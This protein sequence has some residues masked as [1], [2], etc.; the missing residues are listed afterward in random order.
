M[1]LDKNNIFYLIAAFSIV[2]VQTV[3]AQNTSNPR[4]AQWQESLNQIKQEIGSLLQE[5]KEL[6][7]QYKALKGNLIAIQ[8][9][10][11]KIK[12]ENQG[13][14]SDSRQIKQQLLQRDNTKEQLLRKEDALKNQIAQQEARNKALN[15]ELNSVEEAVR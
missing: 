6:D 8:D 4:I 15:Q 7:E 9:E 11:N 3:S 2:C 14:E 5:N 10:I 12:M 1:N 13:I